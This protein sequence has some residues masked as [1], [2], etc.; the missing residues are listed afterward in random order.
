[1]F[2]SNEQSQIC[3]DAKQNYC[4]SLRLCFLASDLELPFIVFCTPP[5]LVSGFHLFSNIRYLEGYS[6]LALNKGAKS[7]TCNDKK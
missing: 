3:Y 1:M 6:V 2:A 5:N 7:P 4:N